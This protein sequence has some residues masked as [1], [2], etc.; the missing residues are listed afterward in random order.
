MNKFYN[1]FNE[2]KK[3]DQLYEAIASKKW[4][5]IK[6]RPLRKINE[7]QVCWWEVVLAKA[8]RGVRDHQGR[9][10]VET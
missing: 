4:K 2:L 5:S 9:T 1:I 7:P 8:L 6:E 10:A 3:N